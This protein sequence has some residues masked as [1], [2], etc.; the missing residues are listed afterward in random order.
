MAKCRATSRKT[1]GREVAAIG[2]LDAPGAAA[3]AGLDHLLADFDVGMKEYRD[4]A[5]IHHRRQNGHAVDRHGL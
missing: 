1:L 3:G 4:H 2:E 5:L